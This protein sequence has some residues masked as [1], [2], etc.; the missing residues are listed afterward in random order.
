MG[1]KKRILLEHIFGVDID[2]QAV[3]VTK[4]SL[5]LRLL[6]GETAQTVDAQHKLLRER[7][8]PE[9]ADN[10]K[11]GNSLV[12]S[13][14]YD[15]HDA[16]AFTDED[17][18]RINAFDWSA[19]FAEIIRRGG[20]DAVI[21][22]PPYVRIQTM[23]QWAAPEVAY[24]KAHYEAAKKGNF[25]LYVAFVEKGLR[26]LGERGRFGY[27]VP[28][29]FLT[30]DYGE[31][32]RSLLAKSE[33]VDGVV[34]FGHQ[35]VFDGATIYTCLLF[36]DNKGSDHITII[37]TKP[38]QLK[39]N[40]IAAQESAKSES[41]ASSLLTGEPWY[42][43]GKEKQEVFD[44]VHSKGV[45][46]LELPALMSRG[47]STGADTVFCL[48]A[49]ALGRL[50]TRD[51]VV[52]EIEPELLRKPIYASDFGRYEFSP[53]NEEVIIFPYRVSSDG[54]EAIGE[55]ELRDDYP[56]TY[57]YLLNRRGEL[58]QRKQIKEWYAYSAPRNLNVHDHADLLIPLLANRGI[59]APAPDTGDQYCLMA[60]G[61]FSVSIGNSGSGEHSNYV[62]GLVN[63]K[64]LFWVLNLISN[65]FRG[66]WITCTK[67]YFGQLPIRPINFDDTEDT[68]HHKKMVALVTQM[69]DLHK[70]LPKAS[71]EHEITLLERR[72]QVTDI[73]ID[74]LVYEL[75]GLTEDEIAIVEQASN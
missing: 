41:M 15:A 47:S 70:R 69:L 18:Y 19:E 14:F 6:E 30:T 36:L 33:S 66:G 25:D 67:Q 1:E 71:N 38:E 10:I 35:Q 57:E 54:Y 4:L 48:R 56:R 34:Y 31:A 16:G 12:G 60:S 11:C 61:G 26:L 45:P 17:H 23:Q 58:D 20:F 74:A 49:E 59:F 46:L 51:G 43:L 55:N 37:K 44:R 7:I 28:N 42:L 63:S 68:A 13:D 29:K 53:S 40:L 9:L 32:L 27:I 3:E 2:P 65:K 52:V 21:G 64:L 62:L 22:N 73:Q 5:L 72:I 50:L 24:I 8:L 39:H 75:Y